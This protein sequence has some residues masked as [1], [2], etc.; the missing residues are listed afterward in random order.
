MT[1]GNAVDFGDLTTAR[2]PA[3]CASPTRALFAG[4]YPSSNIIDSIELATTGNAIDFGDLIRADVY[5]QSCSSS[6]RGIWNGGQTPANTDIQFVTISTLGNAIDYGDLNVARA[7]GFGTSNSVR[8][9][10]GG[11]EGPSATDAVDKFNI[12]SGGTGTDFGDLTATRV[13][14]VAG[15][16]Q[17][18]G[19]L[20]DGYQGTRP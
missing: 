16:S 1:L 10:A 18:H 5:T 11:G 7:L 3:G 8:G 19:G 4:G 14:G 2:S 17:S 15:T 6:T 12:P 13:N 9:F 20:N